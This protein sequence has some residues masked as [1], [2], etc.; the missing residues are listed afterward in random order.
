MSTAQKTQ[1]IVHERRRRPQSLRLRTLTP[2]LLVR[3]LNRSLAWYRDVVGFTVDE[4]YE[5][6]GELKGASLIAGSVRIFLSQDDGAEGRE[7]AGVGLY[8]TTAQ[9]VDEV[10]VAIK[11]RGAT[12]ASEPAD[13]PWG[14]RAFSLADPDGYR[15]TISSEG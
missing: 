6:K 14:V 11:A 13:M 10:A 9:N 1:K 2:S 12:L 8:C 15:V 5:Q 4:M 7:G 3:N